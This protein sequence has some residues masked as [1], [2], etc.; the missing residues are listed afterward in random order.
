MKPADSVLRRP[1]GQVDCAVGI[2]ATSK[3]CS[4]PS[5]ESDNSTKEYDGQR[6]ATH[7]ACNFNEMLKSSKRRQQGKSSSGDF[8]TPLIG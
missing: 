6:P 4:G 8:Q 7:K 3:H 2:A 5:K 1:P